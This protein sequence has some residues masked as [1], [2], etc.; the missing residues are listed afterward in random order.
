MLKLFKGR[1]NS[2]V[3]ILCAIVSDGKIHLYLYVYDIIYK[4]ICKKI[5]VY[6]HVCMH[7]YM[8][9]IQHMDTQIQH[10]TLYYPAL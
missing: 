5:K 6:V 8:E 2:T 9:I 1:K 10:D 3:N 7:V 4:Y